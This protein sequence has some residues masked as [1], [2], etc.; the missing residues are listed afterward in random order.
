[1]NA[2]YQSMPGKR[3]LECPFSSTELSAPTNYFAKV[4][5]DTPHTHNP[6]ASDRRL[7]RENVFE[8]HPW[9]LHSKAVVFLVGG[10]LEYSLNRVVIETGLSG[11]LDHD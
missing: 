1:V 11:C 10:S 9:E 8:N 6:C 7:A 5:L 4:M 3:D 2:I